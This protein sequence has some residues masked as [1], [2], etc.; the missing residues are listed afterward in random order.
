L[1]ELAK[2][3]RQEANLDLAA[4]QIRGC[5]SGSYR[6]VV[7]DYALT[8]PARELAALMPKSNGS[9]RDGTVTVPALLGCAHD[10]K[11]SN[12]GSM[13][14]HINLSWNT[15]EPSLIL[16]HEKLTDLGW[17]YYNGQIHIVEPKTE[18]SQHHVR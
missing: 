6:A 12:T 4:D 1:S 2:L 9:T 14:R 11:V 15:L 17:A 3:E 8:P 18:E 5:S 10:D 13:V 16:I 7:S